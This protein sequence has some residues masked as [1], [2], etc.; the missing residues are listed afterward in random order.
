MLNAEGLE[1]RY[2]VVTGLRSLFSTDRGL[3]VHAVDGV[4]FTVARGE[5]LGLVG[6]SGCGKSTTGKLLVGLEIQPRGVSRSAAKISAPCIVAT[7][8]LFTG[9]SK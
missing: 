3:A 6:E 1:K 2:P 4:D 5:V 7:G 9:G 8:G